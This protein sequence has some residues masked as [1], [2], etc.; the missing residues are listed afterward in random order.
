MNTIRMMNLNVSSWGS[1]CFQILTHCQRSWMQ[2]RPNRRTTARKTPGRHWWMP[3][4]LYMGITANKHNNQTD[5]M[6]CL[7][8]VGWG[9]N[10][11]TSSKGYFPITLLAKS[12]MHSA[13]ECMSKGGWPEF[14]LIIIQEQTM[15]ASLRSPRKIAL[16]FRN[17]LFSSLSMF[18]T[19][20]M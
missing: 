18:G 20:P 10:A 3:C 1:S 17:L 5:K 4:E 19:G 14:M 9:T 8:Q 12:R 7:W 13:A 16:Y 11:N 2:T 6:R 15:E